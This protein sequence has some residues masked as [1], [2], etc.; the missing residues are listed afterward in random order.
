MLPS[1]VPFTFSHPVAVLPLARL[2]WLS[3]PALVVGSM[4]PDFIYFLQLRPGRQFGHTLPGL[5]L[6]SLPVGFVVLF[7]FRV[8]LERPLDDLLPR[9]VGRAVLPFTLTRPSWRRL[10]GVA[11]S[12]LLGALTHIVWDAFTHA[13]G[14]GVAAVPLLNRELFPGVPLHK[15]A[16]HGSSVL[17]LAGIAGWLYKRRNRDP[18]PSPPRFSARRK[19]AVWLSLV[20]GS[21]LLALASSL[22]R[23]PLTPQLDGFKLFVG[24]FV[25]TWISMFCVLLS[26]YALLWHGRNRQV[27]NRRTL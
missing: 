2:K 25:V 9:R 22:G 17:G 24:V 27:L 6:F 3:L 12:L 26:V 20:C 19:V 7:I 4:S 15:L 8:L 13:N 11:I 1:R 14:W 10:L 16:Q 18:L 21:S 23:V 5:F